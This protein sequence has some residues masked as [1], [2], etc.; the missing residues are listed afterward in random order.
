MRRALFGLLG[1]I[2]MAVVGV[3]WYYGAPAVERARFP[4]RYRGYDMLDAIHAP[5]SWREPDDG[6]NPTD[7]YF[8]ANS[9]QP[10]FRVPY[11][12]WTRRYL[13]SN[14]SLAE[15]FRGY[16]AAARAAGWQPYACPRSGLLTTQ[17]HECWKRPNFVLTA[18]FDSTDESCDPK[19][20]NCG[21]S[22]EVELA[23]RA[24]D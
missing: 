10:P 2:V 1:L 16:D 24:P 17:R 21:T 3:G 6:A 7:E 15:T 8:P 4:E 19:T 20:H 18:D 5:G 12:R 13:A 14:T 23:E 9:G 22:I 11:Q